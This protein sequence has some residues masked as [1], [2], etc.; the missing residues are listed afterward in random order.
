MATSTKKKTPAKKKT[1]SKRKSPIRGRKNVTGF[2]Y[3]PNLIALILGLLVIFAIGQLGAVGKFLA[4]LVRYIVGSSY[5]LPLVVLLVAL[6]GMV[7]YGTWPV[8][9]KRRYLIGFGVTYLGIMLALSIL[10]FSKLDMHTGFT[11]AVSAYIQQD[12]INDAVTTPVGGGM[13]GAVI[14]NLSFVALS[15]VGSWILA[16][17]LIV[18]GIVIAFD[19]DVRNVFKMIFDFSAATGKVVETGVQ[20]GFEKSV[21]IA[22]N[23]R[24][25]AT[26]F[27]EAR[28]NKGIDALM[29]S[30]DPFGADVPIQQQNEAVSASVTVAP[31]PVVHPEPEATATTY[32]V[33]TI[34]APE[35][36]I[37]PT[38]ATAPAITA[39][40]KS[41]EDYSEPPFKAEQDV[42]FTTIDTPV[43]SQARP[44]LREPEPAIDDDDD[45]FGIDN[46]PAAALTHAAILGHDND[47]TSPKTVAH[48]SNVGH[49]EPSTQSEPDDDVS[50]N[51]MPLID[52]SKYILPT[53]ALLSQVGSTDQSAERATLEQKA[54]TLNQTLKSFNIDATVEKVILGPTVTQYEIRPAVG[55]KVSKITN[56]ADDLALALAAKSLRIEA[57]IPGKSLVGIEVANE[58]QAMVG[59]RDM[60]DSVGINRDN[61]IEVPIG[62]SISGEIVKMNIK[63]MPHLLIAGSTGSGKSVA[64]NSILASILLQAKPSEVRLML[65]DPKK[66]ELSVYNDIP[67]LITPVVSEPRKA[68]LALKKVVAEMDR[69]FKLL[70]DYG[71]RNIDGY[72][73]MVEKNNAEANGTVLQK[74][75]YLIAIIDEL[76]DLM[77]TVSGEVEPA[78]VRIAQLG[79]AAGIHMIVATQRPSVD[80]ITGLI[81]ANVPSR[82]AFAVSSGV[83]SRTILDSNGAEKLLGRGDMLY[84]PIGANSPQRVQGAFLSDEDVE[85]LTDFIKNQG[86]ANYDDSMTVSDEDVA[87]MANGSENGS[88]GDAHGADTPDELWDEAVAFVVDQQRA[89]TSL[90]QR[91][92]RIG[93]NRAARL[94][95]DLEQNGIIGPAD[96][97]KPR[98]VLISKEVYERQMTEGQS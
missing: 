4:N 60:M 69:R 68:A 88:A 46:V 23:T 52:D 31:E 77:I 94:M 97:A 86:E 92:Y 22:G 91:R 62:K 87:A 49:V 44:T 29:D 93:Y 25:L 1:T 56:L 80:V 26:Q 45:D 2:E 21:E 98:R 13:I 17:V 42:P 18:A 81:K 38:A 16:V 70:A 96:G 61:P 7:A 5:Q 79:R 76:A 12:M 58:Q 67:H 53:T 24:E 6:I 40:P 90:L 57:P 36:V 11:S 64:I 66:V 63:K 8:T 3:T 78:I 28:K 30:D 32:K 75:P 33:P 95:D 47:A 83:D 59:F 10:L 51:A 85:A 54:L 48:Q 35:P 55:V 34:I 9:F 43:I 39:V 37:E 89:S 71:V 72:N 82:M 27:N 15:N 41:A 14:Y 65:V 50:V 74:M 20:T 73:K 84:A 19:L